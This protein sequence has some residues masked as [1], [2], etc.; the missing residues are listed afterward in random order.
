MAGAELL[1]GL[2]QGFVRGK[3]AQEGAGAE[4]PGRGGRLGV[5]VVCFH[6]VQGIGYEEGVGAI[7][8]LYMAMAAWKG[9]G[10]R[11]GFFS[12]AQG[13]EQPEAV[14]GQLAVDERAAVFAAAYF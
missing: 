8:G 14:Q 13:Y 10:E 4:A 7:G 12:A 6:P 9:K 11:T 5:R 1:N 3:E 2:Q